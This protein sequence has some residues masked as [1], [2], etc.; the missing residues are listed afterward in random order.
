MKKLLFISVLIILAACNKTDIDGYKQ[1][2]IEEGSHYAN[3]YLNYRPLQDDRLHQ[4]IYFGYECWYDKSYVVHSGYNKL[5]GLSQ[6]AGVHNKS[7]R[8]VWQPDFDRVGYI[9]LSAYVYGADTTHGYIITE[10]GWTAQYITTVKTGDKFD[11]RIHRWDDKWE[12]FVG[13]TEC[14]WIY[15]DTPTGLMTLLIPY[16]GG[17]DAAYHDMTIYIKEID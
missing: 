12:F 13:H 9:K 2:T 10:S 3:G 16:F 4:E 17:R 8:I 15:A 5:T 14:V 11:I 7:G 6:I 1:Y